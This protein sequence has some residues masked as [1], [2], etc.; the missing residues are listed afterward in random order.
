MTVKG[1]FTIRYFDF[2]A[3][4]LTLLVLGCISKSC[5]CVRRLL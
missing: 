3:G 1:G 2:A 4:V 5:L